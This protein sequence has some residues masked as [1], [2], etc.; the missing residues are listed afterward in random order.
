MT[1]SSVPAAKCRGLPAGRGQVCGSCGSLC[2]GLQVSL[3]F[4]NRGTDSSLFCET[5]R[6]PQAEEICDIPSACPWYN[7]WIV[8]RGRRYVWA[9]VT[10]VSM[11]TVFLTPPLLPETSSRPSPSS[12]LKRNKGELDKSSRVGSATLIAD[13]MLL[14]EATSVYVQP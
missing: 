1:L 7:L 14:H 10:V 8:P 13:T 2:R 4:A 3:H 11:V 5:L 12:R 6:R 9:P